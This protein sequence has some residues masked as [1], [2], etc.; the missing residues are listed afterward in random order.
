MP[1]RSTTTQWRYCKG[2]APMRVGEVRRPKRGGCATTFPHMT[3]VVPVAHMRARLRLAS[4][5]VGRARQTAGTA[6]GITWFIP[7]PLAHAPPLHLCSAT[8]TEL[9]RVSLKVV[10]ATMTPGPQNT[11]CIVCLHGVSITYPSCGHPVSVPGSIIVLLV[12]VLLA[13]SC[14]EPPLP[15]CLIAQLPICPTISH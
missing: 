8:R 3:L 10:P 4:A 9:E 1:L 7:P 13:P 11:P 14:C 15:N 5:N 12:G 6:P 2:A